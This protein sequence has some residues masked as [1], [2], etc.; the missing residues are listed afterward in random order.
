MINN[1]CNDLYQQRDELFIAIKTATLNYDETDLSKIDESK[2]E[3]E[4]FDGL[5]K[6]LNHLTNQLLSINNLIIQHKC[7][8]ADDDE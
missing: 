1:E 2:T 4:R 8:N 3:R 7:Y 5:I 6:E